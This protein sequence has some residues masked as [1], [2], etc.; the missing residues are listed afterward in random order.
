MGTKCGRYWFLRNFYL[1]KRLFSICNHHR[2]RGHISLL[3]MP[4]KASFTPPMDAMPCHIWERKQAPRW[5]KSTNTEEEEEKPQ[6]KEREEH[7]ER[8][9]EREGE[10]QHREF[11]FGL[12][13]SSLILTT[14][15]ST[16]HASHWT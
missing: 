4:D 16:L 9:R 3:S 5:R 11:G 8:E 12:V 10:D 7:G 15:T 13:H 2:A 6:G 1:H 14:F